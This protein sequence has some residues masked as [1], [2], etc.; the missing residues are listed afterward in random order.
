MVVK[1]ARTYLAPTLLAI[2]FVPC[3]AMPAHSGEQNAVQ[4]DPPT[5]L[6]PPA[7]MEELAILSHGARINGLM[8]LA[9]GSGPHAVVAFCMAILVMSAIWILRKQ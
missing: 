5:T 6:Q 7:S 3:V 1:L 9:A 8:Y 4:K 2:T